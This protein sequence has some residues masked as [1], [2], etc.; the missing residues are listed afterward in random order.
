[1]ILAFRVMVSNGREIVLTG[2]DGGLAPAVTSGD[3]LSS[4]RRT[5]RRRSA[6]AAFRGSPT[7]TSPMALPRLSVMRALRRQDR[8][9]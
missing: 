9:H 8:F 5:G 2:Q 1:M 6:R 4:S 3:S 7:S